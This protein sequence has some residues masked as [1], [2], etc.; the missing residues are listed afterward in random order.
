MLAVIGHTSLDE[1]FATIPDVARFQGALAVP[2]RS[3][4]RR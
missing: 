4:R 1:L 3:T 2:P